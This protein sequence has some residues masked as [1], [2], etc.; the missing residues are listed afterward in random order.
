MPPSS[1]YKEPMRY[2]M[3]EYGSD[4]QG[5]E[6]EILLLPETVELDKERDKYYF[7]YDRVYRPEIEKV[8]SHGAPRILNYL[9]FG[10]WLRLWCGAK[11]HD[12]LVFD[13]EEGKRFK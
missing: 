12:I 7:W 3:L 8:W 9:S 4:W 5:E 10:A 1:C 6:T 13:P 2:V 11:D